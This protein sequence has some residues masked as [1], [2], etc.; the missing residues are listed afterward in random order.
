MQEKHEIDL[1]EETWDKKKI[2]V[3]LLLII[4]LGILVYQSQSF[5]LGKDEYKRV[6]GVSIQK[7]VSSESSL[8]SA[9]AL[10][11]QVQEKILDI[12]GQIS[13]LSVSDIA[14]SSPQVQKILQDIQGLENYPGTRAKE[15]CESICSSIQ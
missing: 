8:P 13:G 14:S 1:F 9:S 7:E 15:V 5:V 11:Q 3:G 2:F 10:S 4:G 6:E 12:K